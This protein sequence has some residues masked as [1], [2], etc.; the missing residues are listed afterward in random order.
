MSG[1]RDY[2]APV[3]MGT[4]LLFGASMLIRISVDP[5]CAPRQAEHTRRMQQSDQALLRLSSLTRREQC[6]FY[7]E[8]A[9]LFAEQIKPGDRCFG[10]GRNGEALKRQTEARLYR[11]LAEGCTL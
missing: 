3:L 9:A 11:Q 10:G 6:L 5:S 8:R 7:G 1:W 4:V 2:V